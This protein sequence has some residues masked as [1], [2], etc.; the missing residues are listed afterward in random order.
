MSSARQSFK[1][2]RFS[3]PWRRKA[4]GGKHGDLVVG[5]AVLVAHEAAKEGA[6]RG[7]SQWD[8]A[9]SGAVQQRMG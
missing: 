5:E 8:V 2:A 1:A 4:T 3:G 6:D 7:C 9:E